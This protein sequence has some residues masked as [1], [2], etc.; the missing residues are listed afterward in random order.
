MK[1]KYLLVIDVQNDFVSGALGSEDAQAVLDNICRKVEAFDGV[2]MFTRDTHQPDYLA[3]QEG[4]YLPVEHC[5]KGT[6]GWELVERLNDYAKQHESMI[7]DK[8][9]FGNVY[10]GSDIKSLYKLNLIESIELI[11]LDTDICVIS[12]ALIL[13]AAAPELPIYVDPSCCA[14]SSK[15]RH[16]AAIEVMKSCQIQVLK[17]GE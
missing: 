17:A 11:G 16:D 5:I 6:E 3:T 9:T 1:Q 14:G 10:L 13:K 8:E 15:E 2:V 7:Y 4:K 12:N